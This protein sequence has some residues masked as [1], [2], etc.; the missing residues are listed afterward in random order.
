MGC[1]GK[2]DNIPG[3]KVANISVTYTPK[4]IIAS[5][6]NNFILLQELE[7]LEKWLIIT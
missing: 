5:A 3:A 7:T 6:P 4:N 1:S 2:F